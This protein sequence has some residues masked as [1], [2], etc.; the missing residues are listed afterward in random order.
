MAVLIE[1]NGLILF[2]HN[3]LIQNKY[4]YTFEN[5][6]AEKRKK[7]KTFCHRAFQKHIRKDTNKTVA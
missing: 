2:Y 1:M 3:N 6:S 4:Y 5:E 7:E